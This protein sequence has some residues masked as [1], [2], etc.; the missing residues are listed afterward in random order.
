MYICLLLLDELLAAFRVPLAV[1]LTQSTHD[2]T[3]HHYS[4]K[5]RS[6][7]PPQAANETSV[8]HK[9]KVSQLLNIIRVF[10]LLDGTLS[11][12]NLT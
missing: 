2:V 1:P 7:L 10:V 12:P 11:P 3:K 9:L 4:V 5:N 6:E 8:A